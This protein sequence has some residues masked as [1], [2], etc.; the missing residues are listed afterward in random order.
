M[1]EQRLRFK[2]D[3]SS[4]NSTIVRLL[5]DNAT[6]NG[7]SRVTGL[8][9]STVYGRIDFIHRQFVAFERH[10]LMALRR[11]DLEELSI[12]VDFQD[13][14][15]N[16]PQKDDRRTTQITA[17]GSADN[18]SGFVFGLDM[19][20]DPTIT[21]HWGYFKELLEGGE[22]DQP[23]PHRQSARYRMR[24]FLS[25]A[26]AAYVDAN[27]RAN[28]EPE[29]IDRLVEILQRE[30]AAEDLDEFRPPKAGLLVNK[31][32]TAMAH[33]K[34]LHDIL[35]E[36]AMLKIYGDEDGSTVA[37][38]LSV[39][40]NRVQAGRLGL[41]LVSVNKTMTID[42]KKRLLSES[43][44]AFAA[45]QAATGP[46]WSQV[47]ARRAYI[48]RMSIP[49]RRRHL[50]SLTFYRLPLQTMYE[51]EKA[52]AIVHSPYGD[53]HQP[54][55]RLLD[56]ASLHAIDSFFMFLRSRVQFATRPN[57]PSQ[58]QRLWYPKLPYRPDML[59][60]VLDIARIH[61][62][63]VARRERSLGKF[64]FNETDGE[65]RTPAQRLGLA[66]GPVELKKIIYGDWWK[67]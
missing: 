50:P 55:A 45:F 59:Q 46:Y 61:Y 27:G 23:I 57:M 31:T 51:P 2:Q 28:P 63:F 67:R 53:P 62:N 19:A 48:E 66:Q 43:E 21:D 10:R 9:P 29:A 49:E 56:Y 42:E 8:S 38:V 15:V 17:I 37:A 5:V 41:A 30:T 39:M 7:I 32:Y 26:H 24:E 60:K 36:R 22:F 18:L 4:H 20:Y 6:I 13:Y 33:V 65:K 34:R 44:V 64:Y 16:W 14:L 11:V 52:V 1:T 47:A 35:P 3:S 12:S 58:R 54:D 40:K 25:M